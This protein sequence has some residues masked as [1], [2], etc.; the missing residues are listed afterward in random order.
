MDSRDI[1]KLKSM[2]FFKGLTEEQLV[3]I[4]DK[5]RLLSFKKNDVIFCQGDA[6]STFFIVIQGWVTIAKENKE[7]EQ[8]ILHVF[9]KGESFAEPAA[10]VM[11]SYPASAYAASNC[12]LLE[13]NVS[14]LK[15]MIQKDPDIA[16]RMIARLSG[17]L[18]T[19]VNEFEKYKTM[20]V[21]KRLAIFLKELFDENKK[22][23][24]MD[25]PFNKTVL[26]AYLG[27]QPASLSRAFNKLTQYGVRSSRSGNIILDDFSKLKDFINQDEK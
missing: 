26:A 19:L 1:K 14:A 8:S 2:Q 17:Q 7:A 15:K 12:E 11:G 23:N 9:K 4:C 22:K 27:I 24:R 5:S 13:L 25:L 3:H 10:L 16:M 21:S 6:A 18:N 20:S